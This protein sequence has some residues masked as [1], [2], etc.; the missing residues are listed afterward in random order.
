MILSIL[1]D[2]L[3]EKVTP[4]AV[5]PLMYIDPVATIDHDALFAIT[6]GVLNCIIAHCVPFC[7]CTR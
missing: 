1:I 3:P 6:I 2:P 7:H 5:D 4:V